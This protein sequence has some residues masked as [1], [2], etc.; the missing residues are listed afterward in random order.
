MLGFDLVGVG[1]GVF[2]LSVKQAMIVFR[3][4]VHCTDCMMYLCITC[5]AR[6][7]DVPPSRFH[8]SRIGDP[9]AGSAKSTQYTISILST[10][11]GQAW[12][13]GRGFVFA[14]KERTE[15]EKRERKKA[16]I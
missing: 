1:V 4:S 9:E 16:P 14:Q 8:T 12:S 3:Y 10:E 6:L 11:G 15:R 7:C 2:F 13:K 5:S